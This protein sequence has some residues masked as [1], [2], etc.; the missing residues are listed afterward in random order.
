MPNPEHIF[1]LLIIDVA[2]IFLF[3]TVFRI[4]FHKERQYLAQ[5]DAMID[6]LPLPLS[7][8]YTMDSISKFRSF[9]P[10]A[11][12]LALLTAQNTRELFE[13][14]SISISNV[15]AKFEALRA[16]EGQSLC[17]IYIA[18]GERGF[19][20]ALKEADTITVHWK[21]S[22]ITEE[23]EYLNSAKLSL[24]E[25]LD[26]YKDMHFKD[27][28]SLELFKAKYK[29]YDG[30]DFSGCYTILCCP[31]GTTA[32]MAECQYHDVYVGQST[33][34][35]KRVYEDLVGR[36]NADVYADICNDGAV[37]I[38]VDEVP[39]DML[40]ITADALIE[41]WGA[42]VSYNRA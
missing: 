9:D 17:R 41:Q 3:I 13:K 25:I 8:H 27:W 38:R 22:S 16:S 20:R 31:S 19:V 39:E 37:F 4:L 34:V 29:Q 1:T 40:S 7:Y 32:P 26:A 12:L 36:G 42:A 14:T 23:S 11:P 10:R 18:Q 28:T 15:K 24:S 6:E 35:L 33:K 21:Y 5:V 2:A 30:E